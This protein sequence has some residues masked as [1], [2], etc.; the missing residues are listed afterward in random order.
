[1]P[2][3]TRQETITVIGS[4]RKKKGGGKML[5]SDNVLNILAACE[6][7]GI[8]KAWMNKNLRGGETAEQVVRLVSERDAAA[9]LYAFEACKAAIKTEIFALGDAIDGV[10]GIG[11]DDFP[12]I[13]NGVKDGDRP[14]ALFYKG[15]ISLIK[16][17]TGNVAVIG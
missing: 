7:R 15:D 4:V 17:V 8:G 3:V 12:Q 16:T 1:M 14:I 13:Q 6:Y 10:T 5:I 9:N 11:D 2:L